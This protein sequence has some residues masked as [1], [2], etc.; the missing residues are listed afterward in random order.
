M[1][2]DKCEVCVHAQLWSCNAYLPY[3]VSA[4]TKA[5]DFKVSELLTTASPAAVYT[6]TL[7]NGTLLACS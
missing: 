5:T 2:K 4:F 1:F 6:L 3:I 7:G